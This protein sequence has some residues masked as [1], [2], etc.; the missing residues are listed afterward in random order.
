MPALITHHLFGED[1]LPELPAG[2]VEG[3]EEVLA[4]L[5]GNQGP[6]PLFARSSRASRRSPPTHSPVTALRTRSRAVGSPGPS[7]R[8]ATE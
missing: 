2:L 1:V 5:L 4:F 8:C 3:E 6:D 7:S